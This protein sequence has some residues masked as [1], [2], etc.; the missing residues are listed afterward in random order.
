VSDGGTVGDS[1]TVGDGGTVGDAGLNDSGGSG[2]GVDSMDGGGGVDSVDGG[3]GVN[4]VDSGGDGD[5]R[6]LDNGG[7]DLNLRDDGG[8]DGDI[9][10]HLLDMDFRLD[11]SHLGDDGLDRAGRGKDPLLGD[12][13]EGGGDGAKVGLD[14]G[15]SVSGD[16]VLG[17]VVDG[18]ADGLSDD[19]SVDD[20]WGGEPSGDG[21]DGDGRGGVD[22][23]DGGGSG[24]G[25]DSRGSVD[26]DATMGYEG[27]A[28]GEQGGSSQVAGRPPA[29]N[30]RGSRVPGIGDLTA[31]AQSHTG[32]QHH[33]LHHIGKGGLC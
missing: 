21:G 26:S 12:S 29:V 3:S 23:V 25:V 8:V 17:S 32:Q 31:R 30:D 28:M 7:A 13:V 14:D 9:D 33:Q 1:G 27:A 24:D 18:L 2:D 15:G 19:G 10:G 20:G 6:A 16:D 11:L 5:S 4:S 22:S